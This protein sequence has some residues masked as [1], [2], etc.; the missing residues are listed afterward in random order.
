MEHHDHKQLGEECAYFSLHPTFHHPEL[1]R[2]ELD[3]GPEAEA[4]KEYCL[5]A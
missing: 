2:Q 5:L 1:S 3:A 4:M